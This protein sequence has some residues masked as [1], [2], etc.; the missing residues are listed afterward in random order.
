[1]I[2]DVRIIP[3]HVNPDARGTLSTIF[4]QH[5]SR[6][7][8]PM[9]QWNRVHSHANVLRGLHAHLLY[10][11]LYV[12][13]SGRMFFL[14]KDARRRSPTFGAEMS[15]YSDEFP[16]S[17]ILVPIGV[18]H[19]VY[20]ETEGVLLYGLSAIYDGSG[21]FGCR[22]NDSEVAC[23]WPATEPSLSERDDCAGTFSAM[24][25]AMEQVASRQRP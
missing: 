9:Q 10:D 22:W 25:D 18:A 8:A 13:L 6:P 1:M 5:D 11:E 4:S 19:G 12:P 17:S 21:E 24:A 16:A 20:F 15:F 23:R 3:H 2:H 7:L 14:L